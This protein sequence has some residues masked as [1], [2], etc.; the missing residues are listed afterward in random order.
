MYFFVIFGVVVL[1]LFIALITGRRFSPLRQNLLETKMS[2]EKFEAQLGLINQNLNQRLE[3]QQEAIREQGKI[4][5]QRLALFSELREK[6]GQIQSAYLSMMEVSRELAGGIG[7]LKNI[8]TAATTRGVSGEVLLENLLKQFVPHNYEMQYLLGSERVDAVIKL[9][10]MLVPIDAKFPY[11]DRFNEM[12]AVDT[13]TGEGEKE[14]QKKK[15]VLITSVKE[16][17]DDVHRKYIRPDL[18][19]SNFAMIYIPAENIYYELV[20]NDMTMEIGNYANQK[21]VVLV[22]PSTMFSY[23]MIIQFGLK[24]MKLEEKAELIFKHLEALAKEMGN[25]KSDFEVM[26]GHLT[27]AYNKLN[28]TNQSLLKVEARFESVLLPD[29]SSPFKQGPSQK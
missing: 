7:N 13:G 11:F 3:S 20:V 2:M 8:F 24:G 17:I 23:L 1:C 10:R 4:V 21:N 19:T 9:D 26:A 22:S 25:F 15:K 29:S 18:N 5:D 28:E 14:K 6:I 16:M 12:L 27:R